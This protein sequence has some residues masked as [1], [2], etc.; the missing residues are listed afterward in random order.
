MFTG[1]RGQVSGLFRDPS[2][3]AV[4]L[5]SPATACGRRFQDSITAEHYKPRPRGPNT[6]PSPKLYAWE[7]IFLAHKSTHLEQG[8]PHPLRHHSN[9]R[10]RAIRKSEELTEREL[11]Y[12]VLGSLSKG[13]FASLREEMVA[14]IKAYLAKVHAS[15]AEDIACFNLD[16][17]WIDR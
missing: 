14:F 13:D 3:L 16:F 11:M 8:S 2:E 12:T 17:F 5:R 1:I 4:T 7:D 6:L 10:I 15:P 9:W